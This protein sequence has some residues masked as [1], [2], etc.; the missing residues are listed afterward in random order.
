MDGFIFCV[1]GYL[2]VPDHEKVR[3]LECL[4]ETLPLGVI[5]RRERMLRF[6]SEYCITNRKKPKEYTSQH[7][8]C[9]IFCSLVCKLSA[10]NY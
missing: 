6:P 2:S 10:V 5:L 1:N 9:W 8:F 3:M 7:Y 4:E